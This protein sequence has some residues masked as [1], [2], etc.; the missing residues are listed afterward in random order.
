MLIP[1]NGRFTTLCSRSRTES[2]W[3]QCGSGRSTCAIGDRKVAIGAHASHTFRR[4]TLFATKALTY[5]QRKRNH[6]QPGER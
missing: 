6:L 1:V 2:Q 4:C 5:L 3:L